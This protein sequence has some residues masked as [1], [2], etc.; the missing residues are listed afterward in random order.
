MN[1]FLDEERTKPV[2]LAFS[3]TGTQTTS[4]VL[5]PAEFRGCTRADVES[6]IAKILVAIS[7]GVAFNALD[8]ELAANEVAS[9]AR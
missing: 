2:L 3:F 1:D 6:E 4:V 8:V 5:D 7:P 9:S